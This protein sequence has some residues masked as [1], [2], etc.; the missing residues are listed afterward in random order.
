VSSGRADCQFRVGVGFDRGRRFV[1][2]SK[3]AFRDSDALLHR[4][5]L[6]PLRDRTRFPSR[7]TFLGLRTP[8]PTGISFNDF[9]IMESNRFLKASAQLNQN[10]EPVQQPFLVQ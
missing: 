10:L 5:A 6:E 9:F 7:L 8:G 2:G 1:V 4:V 3:D